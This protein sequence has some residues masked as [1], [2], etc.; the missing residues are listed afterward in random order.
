MVNKRFPAP[1]LLVLA[2][3]HTAPAAELLEG[4]LTCEE[5]PDPYTRVSARVVDVE[6]RPLAH[7]T[8]ELRLGPEWRVQRGTDAQGWATFEPV[9]GQH[10]FV[11]HVS[12]AG[13]RR[14]RPQRLV[15]PSMAAA[16]SLES[17]LTVLPAADEAPPTLSAV[18]SAQFDIV[19]ERVA[20]LRG[21]VVDARGR[22]QRRFMLNGRWRDSPDGTFEQPYREPEPGERSM[23]GFRV[24]LEEGGP[25][26]F[27][28][29]PHGTFDAG[30]VEVPEEQTVTVTVLDEV[31]APVEGAEVLRMN[32]ITLP[33]AARLVRQTDASGRL[34]IPKMPHRAQ[35]LVV[36]VGFEFTPASLT[37]PA[38]V[39]RVKRLA[40]R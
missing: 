12:L 20:P 19:M 13:Y 36:A 15:K 3:A 8:V 25:E 28:R 40:R 23:P 29:V 6:G 35:V 9:F 37:A 27:V 26:T 22:P 18:G 31:G 33:Y 4:A 7:A 21:R 38:A 16:P 30:D 10:S 17:S 1:L 14:V 34:Q 11:L 2:V 32:P 24:Q 39:V 5:P